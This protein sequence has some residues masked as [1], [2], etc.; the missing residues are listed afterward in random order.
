MSE[1]G[2]STGLLGSQERDHNEADDKHDASGP[3]SL[4]PATGV[5]LGEQVSDGEEATGHQDSVGAGER[6]LLPVRNGSGE[7][8]LAVGT[9]ADPA[10]WSM[11]Q[12][13][14]F[15]RMIAPTSFVP[16]PLRGDPPAVLACIMT[17]R[18]MQLGPMESLQHVFIVDGR[19]TLSAQVMRAMIQRAGHEF[20]ITEQTD[21]SCTVAGLRAGSR[22]DGDI[23]LV[24]WTL[25]D[26]QRAGLAGKSNW[27]TYPR[28][29]LLARATSELARALF[30]DVLGPARYTPEELG[31]Q[32]AE[33]DL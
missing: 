14:K 6:D 25:E 24:T 29:M 31:G 13:L 27:K 15:C 12:L 3:G 18:E 17:G 21:D 16:K 10:L 33:N 19:P 28:A 9:P 30:A 4:V 8:V 7:G 20:A 2:R 23:H 22:G 32:A 1:A 11:D 26:A 5:P